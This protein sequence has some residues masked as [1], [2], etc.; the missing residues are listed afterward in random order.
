MSLQLKH[1]TRYFTCTVSLNP[2]NVKQQLLSWL[3]GWRNQDSDTLSDFPKI[4]ELGEAEPGTDPWSSPLE[5]DMCKSCRPLSR[6]ALGA[7]TS[8]P[9]VLPHSKASSVWEWL[10]AVVLMAVTVPVNGIEAENY[11]SLANT[12]HSESK[13]REGSMDGEMKAQWHLLIP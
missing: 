13:T 2:N 1:M 7:H 9:E 10:T 5:N 11:G 3:I 12:R 8:A 6:R 4:T